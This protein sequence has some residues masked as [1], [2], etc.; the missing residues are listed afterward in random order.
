MDY[1][2]SVW[3]KGEDPY[4]V[5]VGK[6]LVGKFCSGFGAGFKEVWEKT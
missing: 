6:V 5:C 4:S 3:P 1:L 2:V